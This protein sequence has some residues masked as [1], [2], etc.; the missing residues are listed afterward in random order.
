MGSSDWV[1]C[2]CLG[3]ICLHLRAGMGH[4]WVCFKKA[5]IQNMNFDLFNRSLELE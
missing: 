3:A 5:F 4:T 1:K 2:W